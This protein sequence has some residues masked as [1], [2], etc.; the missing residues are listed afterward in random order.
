VPAHKDQELGFPC[1]AEESV[2]SARDIGV[3]YLFQP[4]QMLF[5][6]PILLLLTLHVGFIY[7]FLYICFEAYPISFQYDRGWQEGVAALAFVAII[8]GVAVACLIIVIFSLT[9]YRSILPAL[10]ESIPTNG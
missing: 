7:V 3:R 10:D 5:Q 2:V 6:E 9:R 4:F 8:C 1:Q